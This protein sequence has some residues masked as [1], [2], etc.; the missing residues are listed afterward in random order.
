MRHDTLL[1]R[2]ARAAQPGRAVLRITLPPRLARFLIAAGA[3]AASNDSMTVHSSDVRA[4]GVDGIE[5]E[6]PLTAD[7]PS[8]QEADPLF[9]EEDVGAETAESAI[10][11]VDPSLRLAAGMVSCP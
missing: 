4:R 6:D 7:L 3:Q 5:A 2:L 8:P 1:P 11:S 9:P 10:I